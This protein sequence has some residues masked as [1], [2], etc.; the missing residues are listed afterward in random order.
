MGIDPEMSQ[1]ERDTRFA[2]LRA[3]VAETLTDEHIAS[4]RSRCVKM[5][6]V[7]RSNANLFSI[8][9]SGH[10]GSRR[11]G[12]QVGTLLA[13]AFSL[14]SDDEV[15]PAQ[16]EEAMGGQDFSEQKAIQ[17]VSDEVSLLEKIL[18]HVVRVPA[19][20]GTVDRNVG[21]LIKFA[22]GLIDN[23]SAAD[24]A[25]ALLLIGIKMD[26]G[27]FIVANQHTGIENI[28]RGTHW[29]RDWGRV[30]KRLPDAV[31]GQKVRF[32]EQGNRR[33]TSLSVDLV[34]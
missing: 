33:G 14:L 11:L 13:G 9:A 25:H 10:I 19:P 3:R 22:A 6:P 16:A 5:I 8:A 4:F 30:L 15:T 32:G 31:K 21:S 24:A 20:G 1:E 34:E 17:A 18:Q 2:N 26:A 29:C 23:V 27:R 28:L 12:D 7:I